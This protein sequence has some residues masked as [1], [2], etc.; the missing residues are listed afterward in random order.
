M[1]DTTISEHHQALQHL[2]AL[3]ASGYPTDE[4][5]RLAIDRAIATAP[6]VPEADKPFKLPSVMPCWGERVIGGGE[7]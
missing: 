6:A 2:K 7:P 5:L 1:T 4:D 3:A